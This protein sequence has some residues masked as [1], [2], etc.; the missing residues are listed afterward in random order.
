M[1]MPDMQRASSCCAQLDWTKQG[2]RHHHDATTALLHWSQSLPSIKKKKQDAPLKPLPDVPFICGRFIHH[3]RIRALS[4]HGAGVHP[5]RPPP[6][7]PRAAGRGC[8]DCVIIALFFSNLPSD[9]SPCAQAEVSWR[10]RAG[11]WASPPRCG[12][13]AAEG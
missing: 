10:V 7:R 9:Q 11:F 3:Y 1:T 6:A 5:P 4:C 13:E 2:G 12:A 8:N